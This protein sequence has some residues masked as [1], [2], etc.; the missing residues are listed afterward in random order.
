MSAELNI[1]HATFFLKFRLV[2]SIIDAEG[3][4][5]NQCSCRA[6][7]SHLSVGSG[8]ATQISS[9]ML[10]AHKAV[11][12]SKY[13]LDRLKEHIRRFS[14]EYITC[15]LSNRHQISFLD[16]S[17]FSIRDML[18]AR[19]MLTTPPNAFSSKL[20]RSHFAGAGGGFHDERGSAGNT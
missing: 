20:L 15:S 5:R 6:L 2:G 13:R 14:I 1:F 3:E 7:R 19:R 18:P 9:T 16:E 17:R 10:I 8:N 12:A 4:T 11:L